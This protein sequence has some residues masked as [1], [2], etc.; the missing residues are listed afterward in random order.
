MINEPDIL[1][2]SDWAILHRPEVWEA[3]RFLHVGVQYECLLSLVRID[4]GKSFQDFQ[5]EEIQ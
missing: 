1:D 2:L 5:D 4:G 3:I